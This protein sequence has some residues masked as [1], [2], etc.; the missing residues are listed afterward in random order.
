MASILAIISKKVFDRDFRV[1]GGP[2]GLGDVVPTTT[3]AS[4]HAALTKLADGGDMFLVTVAPGEQ[5][6]LAGVLAR[7]QLAKAGWVAPPCKTPI[8]DITSLIP[9]LKF[10]NGKG[11]TARAGA[12]AMSLQTPRT[13]SDEDVALLRAVTG[14]T[15]KP[16]ATA[17]PA[18]RS[19]PAPPPAPRVAP[20][21]SDGAGPLARAQ[22][23]LEQGAV[24]EA[25]DDLLA[26]WAKHKA[27]EIADLVD[28]LGAHLATALPPIEGKKAALEAAWRDVADQVRPV[29]VPR[30]LAAFEGA[31]SGQIEGWLDVL[32]DRFPI[33]PRMCAVAVETSVK[34]VASSAGPTR[35]RANKLAERIADGR[36]IPLIER[37]IAKKTDAWNDSE[38]RDRLRK[39]RARFAPPPALA[40]DDKVI[41]AALAKAIA[42]IE[43]HAPDPKQLTRAKTS[44][45]DDGSR[46]LAEVLADPDSEAPRM[47]FMDWLQQRGD[48]RGEVM[49]LAAGDE[50]AAKLVKQH[51]KSWLGPLAAVVTEPVF[52]SGFLTECTV[53]LA[54]KKHREQVLLEPLWATVKRVTCEE[55]AVVESP[56]MKSL[57]TVA[58][59]SI[60]DH[61]EL[62]Q[63]K[64]PL[65]IE[66]I[67]GLEIHDRVNETSAPWQTFLG[68]G[69]FTKLR[70]LE[71]DAYW[72]TIRRLGVAPGNWQWLLS[73]KLCKQLAKLHID[74]GREAPAVAA[75]APAFTGE[76]LVL[77]VS[78][79]RGHSETV[80]SAIVRR[81]GKQLAYALELGGRPMRPNTNEVR[82]EIENCP[83]VMFAGVEAP[84]LDVVVT[85]KLTKQELD[86]LSTHFANQLGKQFAKI[87]VATGPSHRAR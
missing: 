67:E 29:D 59:L 43:K 7:P 79:D 51:G 3:Y 22:Q 75:W 26:A 45:T 21:T 87:T 78:Y 25:L 56:A 60:E 14:G 53:K 31:S 41:V 85:G 36:C 6:W 68:V 34:F 16:K 38:L 12:L 71:V 18:K 32:L 63:R 27:A 49:S 80:T 70:A 13:L 19:T 72:D 46:L 62:A 30:L 58:G 24:V 55:R 23:H 5:L 35:T 15:S 84:R 20:S 17:A 57:R 69:A 81:H 73:S 2:A 65:A 86:I 42:R 64:Q 40:K 44:S 9:Q 33:D 76:T 8:I 28:D 4:T 74:F 82:W 47:V 77:T 50:R 11:L 83:P 1:G 61:A 48:P 52:E 54:S 39:L 66:S 37:L 10:E